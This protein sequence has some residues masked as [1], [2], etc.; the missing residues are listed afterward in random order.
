MLT[1][2]MIDDEETSLQIAKGAFDAFFKM[3]SMETSIRSF[4]NPEVFLDSLR[5]TTYDLVCSDIIMSPIDGIE[6]A[7]RLRQVD[8][9]VPLIFIS[10]N[11]TNVFSCFEYDPIGFI[12][13]TNFLNDT[14]TMMKH[15]YNDILPNR[16]MIHKVEV[17]SHGEVMLLNLNDILYIEGNHNYQVIHVRNQKETIEVRK[18]ISDMERE[19]SPY[20]FIRVHKGFLVNYLYIYKFSHTD[21]TLKDGTKIPISYPNRENIITKYMELTKGTI[22]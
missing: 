14:Q 15:Y 17:K 2:A 6:L 3:M 10:S 12:R 11:E 18:L 19:L 16:K 8:K 9:E 20:G 4:T 5:D 22:I 13:K 21:V 7:K 1:I